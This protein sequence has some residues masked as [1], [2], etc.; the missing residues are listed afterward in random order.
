[1]RLEDPA[2]INV[3]RVLKWKT[4][5]ANRMGCRSVVGAVK[6]GTRLQLQYDDDDNDDDVLYLQL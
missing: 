5:T 1:M 4:K 2:I 6:A 3:Y